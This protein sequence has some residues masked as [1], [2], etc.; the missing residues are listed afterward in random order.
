VEFPPDGWH[1]VA[2]ESGETM[3]RRQKAGALVLAAD[4][5]FTNWRDRLVALA[6]RHAIPTVYFQPEF[7]V[8]GGLM[9]YG[10][11]LIDAFRQAGIYTGRVL[12]GEK[13]ADL[14]VVQPTCRNARHQHGCVRIRI[15]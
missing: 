7:V 10:N 3:N 12:K 14:P 5:L 13:P 2:S 8:A 6:A 9:S 4:P 11:S 1:A 15:E